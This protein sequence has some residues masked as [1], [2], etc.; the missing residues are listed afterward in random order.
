MTMKLTSVQQFMLYALGTCYAELDERFSGKPVEITMSKVDFIDL[1]HKAA[2]VSKKDR[3]VYKNLESL[4]KLKL[5]A[6]N[7]KVIKLTDRGKKEYEKIRIVINPYI[8][9]TSTLTSDDILNY[10]N[11]A[12]TVLK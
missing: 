7:N 2:I 6:Y 5:I 10:T 9:V 1:I 12:Q 8:T 4:E 3:A 11:H